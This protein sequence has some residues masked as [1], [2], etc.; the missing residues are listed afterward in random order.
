MSSTIVYTL[1][2][3]EVVTIEATPEGEYIL[4]EN[5]AEE[6]IDHLI[7]LFKSGPRNQALLQ[8][9]ALQIQE[10]ENTS[11]QVYTSFY[12]DTAVGDQLDILGRI[13]GEARQGRL[14]A[15]YRAAVKVR[16]LVNSSDGKIEQLLAIA[17]GMVPS[18]SIALL[19]QF[20]CTIRMEFSTMGTSTLRTVFAML[21]QAKA[22]GVRLLVSYGPPTIGAVDGNPLGGTIGAVDG[23]PLG[24]T[25]SGG[26]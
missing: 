12:V 23:S 2:S 20:P 26:T 1:P 22:A 3:G 6:A 5:H 9:V 11:A 8:V 18:A 7:E 24:F 10:L 16:I 19:E 17:R 25:I 4:N 13:V 14:D 15:E 21:Q